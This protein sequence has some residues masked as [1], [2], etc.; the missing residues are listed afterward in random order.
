MHKASF[1]RKMNLKE[2]IE[3]YVRKKQPYDDKPANELL[4]PLNDSCGL[5]VDNE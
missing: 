2:T 1:D 5:D 3:A 4:D